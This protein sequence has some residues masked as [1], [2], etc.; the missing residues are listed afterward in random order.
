MR[1]LTA[2]DEAMRRKGKVDYCFGACL[3]NGPPRVGKSTFFYRITGRRL[4]SSDASCETTSTGVAETILQVVIKKSTFCVARA[5]EPGM[6]WQIVTLSQEA[7]TMLKAIISSQSS[8]VLQSQV[9]PLSLT[10]TSEFESLSSKAVDSSADE[11]V[12]EPVAGGVSGTAQSHL[13][14]FNFGRHKKISRQIRGYQLPLEIFQKALRS[15]EWA[16][17]EDLLKHS[18]NL[19]FSDVGGQPEFQEV[20]PAIIAGP[21]VFFILFKLPDSLSQKYRVQYI[22]S[23]TRKTIKYESSFTV[24]ESILCSLSSASSMC[25]FVTRNSSELEPI[26]PKVF[27]VATHKDKADEKHIKNV[28]RELKDT[29]ENTEFY[30]KGIV[31]FASQSEPAFTINNLSDD[32]KDVSNIRQRVEK[33]IAEDPSFKVSVPAPWLA[34]S[35]SLKL[36]ESS[37]I[38]YESCCTIANDCGIDDEEEIK[39]ALW[40]LHNKLGVIRY[41]DQVPELR[42]IVVCDPQV[43]FDILTNL[44]TRTFTF[45][46]TQDACASEEFQRKGIFPSRMIDKISRRLNEPLTGLKVV[47]LLKHLRVVAEIYDGKSESA[48]SYLVPCALSHA[49]CHS[50]PTVGQKCKYTLMTDSSPDIPPL[51]ILFR[52]GYCPKGIFG[53]LIADLLNHGKTKLRWLLIDDTIFRDQVSFHVGREHHKVKISSHITFLEVDISADT[54]PAKSVQRRN[55]EIVCDSIRLEIEQSLIRVSKTLHYGSGAAFSFGFH[56]TSCSGSLPADCGDEDDPVVMSCKKCKSVNL[57]EKH[58]FWFGEKGR[59][60]DILITT[61]LPIIMEKIWDARVKWYNIG[62]GLRINPGTL[63]AIEKSNGNV[64]D[65]FRDVL[66]VWLKTNQPQPTKALLAEALQSRIVGYG[67]LAEHILSL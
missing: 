16:S 52:C 4:L 38:S 37:V 13:R 15:K 18:I 10:P 34:L 31:V 66:G 46:E 12:R 44:I 3:L 14:M 49:P 62:L 11:T 9:Q 19:G 24:K 45:E 42:D 55:V 17:A 50:E 32:D 22:E 8:L 64:D 48:S 47:T 53:A 28:Q 26:N 21:S 23:S 35:L 63:D 65:Q 60:A 57:S 27:I 36:V 54:S 67:Y 59:A 58:R 30:K 7:V 51:C 20:L 40:F 1:H 43:I 29:L 61:D 39:E 33:I 5:I 2:C 56:C 41:F 6:N 25:R